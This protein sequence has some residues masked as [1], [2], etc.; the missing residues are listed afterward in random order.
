MARA[1]L[2]GMP[3]SIPDGMIAASAHVLNISL[4]TRNVK[5]FQT[6]GIVLINPWLTISK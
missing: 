6:T 1:L 4:A 3:M 2:L 5:D